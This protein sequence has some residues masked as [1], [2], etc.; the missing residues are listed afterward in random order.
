MHDDLARIMKKVVVS[1]GSSRCWEFQGCRDRNGYGRAHVNGVQ[2]GAHRASYILH[3]G[4]VPLG[5]YLDH[6]CRNPCC[7]NP[8]HLEAV[9]PREN[10]LRGISF[11]AVNARKSS[12]VHGHSLI[13]PKNVYRQ[14]GQRR[15]CR[16]C[17]STAVARYKVRKLQPRTLLEAA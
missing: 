2:M 14:G 9:T 3:R 1:P 17:N 13:D 5:L 8:K 6:L 16:R 7:V 15:Q 11:S 10:V 4:P 12:C